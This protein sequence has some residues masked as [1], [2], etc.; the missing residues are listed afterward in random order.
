MQDYNLIRKYFN[1][2]LLW[3]VLYRFN[4][5]I[6]SEYHDLFPYTFVKKSSFTIYHTQKQFRFFRKLM[7]TAT[8]E[9]RRKIIKKL[10][11]FVWDRFYI[12]EP[13]LDA[14][15]K[16][17][18][19]FV[20]DL[21][22][23]DPKE[24]AELSKLFWEVKN[25]VSEGILDRMLE[26]YKHFINFSKVELKKDIDEEIAKV[27]E[28][29]LKWMETLIKAIK[30]KDIEK[31]PGLDPT[32]CDIGNVLSEYNLLG[33]DSLIKR[34]SSEH[35]RLHMTS[36]FILFFLKKEN[37]CML[38]HLIPKVFKLS[39][40]IVEFIIAGYAQEKTIQYII[41]PLTGTLSRARMNQILM[42]NMEISMMT[43]KSFSLLMIDIDNFKKVN[44][45]YG[46][47][48]GDTVLKKVGSLI[49]S[50]IREAD[51]VF[52][53]GGE[54]F[55][56]VLP[57][58]G[59]HTATDIGNKIRNSIE[60]SSLQITPSSQEKQIFLKIT[61]SIGVFHVSPSFAEKNINDIIEEV[62][63]RLYKA[64]RSGKNIVVNEL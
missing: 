49:L 4:R 19:I 27:I 9:E 10:G 45:T 5:I 43:N 2:N 63:K 25:Y 6:Y 64:K 12:F 14:L 52:R 51:L 44:D 41:D 46:H 55:L 35:L 47:T 16:L 7:I 20:V 40:T 18:V 3:K 23:N 60:N 58:T 61:V 59:L 53:Y 32:E 57:G 15:D 36:E 8:K 34:I 21:H 62:D 31:F 54:E 33:E 48:V 38:L 1:D 17:E 24:K 30:Q 50:S 42:K 26:E 29:H 39:N 37:Y 56:V 13:F 22:I 11:N 28:T